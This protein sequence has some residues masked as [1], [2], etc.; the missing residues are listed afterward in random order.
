MWMALSSSDP[1]LPKWAFMFFSHNNRPL[2]WDSSSSLSPW[3]S[4]VHQAGLPG[5]LW[6]PFTWVIF[7]SK[8]SL[9]S[10]AFICTWGHLF[11]PG[12]G[13]VPYLE[14]VSF[15]SLQ[16]AHPDFYPSGLHSGLSLYDCSLA[17][18]WDYQIAVYVQ[19]YEGHCLCSWCIPGSVEPV[20]LLFPAQS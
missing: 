8:G 5:V 4:P 9:S 2:F 19:Q 20:G 11:T 1:L 13:W 17:S 10:G 18:T 6:W 16:A 7:S 3:L 14:N 15:P 12:S